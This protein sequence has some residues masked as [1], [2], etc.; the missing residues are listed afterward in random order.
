MAEDRVRIGVLGAARIVPQALLRPAS[1]IRGLD[2]VAIAARDRAKADAFARKHSIPMV[3]GSYDGLLAD[4]SINA[5]YIPLPPS[6]HA[7]WAIA[8]LEAGKH[9]LVEKP[10]TAEPDAAVRIVNAVGRS[11]RVL[12]EAYHSHH[13]PFQRRLTEIVR[14][15]ELGQI[16]S[17]RATFCVPIPPGKDIRWQKALGGGALLDLGYYPTRLLTEL[18][19]PPVRVDDARASVMREV[20]RRITATMTY[21]GDVRGEVVASMWSARLFDMSLVVTGTHGRMRVTFPYHPQH[22]AR[23]RVVANGERR[24]EAAERRSTYA[25]QAETFRDAVLDGAAIST[26]AEE[27]AA[28]Q[29]LLARIAAAAGLEDR[30]R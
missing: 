29:R 21:P 23:A 20:D 25:F 28:H 26:G 13:H 16:R 18:L 30:A 11:D 5:V 2:V 24:E 22:G 9:V 1:E 14:S 4:D 19:G 12:M 7:P 17:A 27:A 8:A 15:G 6:L 10:F 3:H